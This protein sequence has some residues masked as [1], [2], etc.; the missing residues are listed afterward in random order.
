MYILIKTRFILLYNYT[1]IV[2]YNTGDVI[3]LDVE[4]K[5]EL[6]AFNLQ[7]DIVKIRWTQNNKELAVDND[8]ERTILNSHQTYLPT[9]PNLNALSS[10]SR[11]FDF[12]LA[13]CPIKN[14]LN[15][16]I[17]CLTSGEIYISVFGMLPCGRIDISK[18]LNQSTQTFTISDVKFTTDFHELQVV[19]NTEIENQI[20]VFEN[21]ILWKYSE[22]LL[23]LAIKYSQ[24][25]N[26]MAYINDTIQSITEAWE[27]VLLEMDN[28]LTKYADSQREGAVPADFLELLVFG[29]P[30]E[31]LEQFLIR[32]E[33]ILIPI[34]FHL[35]FSLHPFPMTK[36]FH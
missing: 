26:T 35:I 11:K 9:L 8:N 25:T 3:L 34:R 17:V 27:T 28:K 36:N 4:N 23:K 21:D 22:S 5:D 2:A 24:I 6:H 7:S 33:F 18:F 32:L 30:S 15:F 19:V 29:H 12:S 13:K 16:L 1:F 20:I 14:I 31:E 10:N